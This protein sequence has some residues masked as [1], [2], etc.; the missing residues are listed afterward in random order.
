MGALEDE[1]SIYITEGYATGASVHMATHVPVV[2]TFDAGNLEPVIE[3]LRKGYPNSPFIIAGDDDC[4]KDR[5]IGREK[6]QEAALKYGC[7]FVFPSF[8]ETASKPTDFNDLLVLEG[9]EE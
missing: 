6:A 1:K 8:K 2:I 9:L 4:W 7:S 5:N 3:E